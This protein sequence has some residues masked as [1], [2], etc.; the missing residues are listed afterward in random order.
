[1]ELERRV[2]LNKKDD[3][4]QMVGKTNF[5][6]T[7]SNSKATMRW[8]KLNNLFYTTTVLIF[9]GIPATIIVYSKELNNAIRNIRHTKKAF[10]FSVI[11]VLLFLLFS[12]SG[13]LLGIF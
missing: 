11:G 7:Q 5:A 6:K 13:A 4:R 8:H 12:L 10:A 9:L 2:A 1:M 3:S